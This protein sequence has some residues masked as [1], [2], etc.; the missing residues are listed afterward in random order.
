MAGPCD[1]PKVVTRKRW[2]KVFK[3]WSVFPMGGN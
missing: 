3:D 2:P 1:S